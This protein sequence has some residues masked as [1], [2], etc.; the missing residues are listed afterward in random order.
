MG[1]W[2]V[3]REWLRLIALST[4]L[5]IPVPVMAKDTNEY[6]AKF[7]FKNKTAGQRDAL[8]FEILGVLPRDVSVKF[9]K[10]SKMQGPITLDNLTTRTRVRASG[11]VRAVNPG[12]T[13][14][15]EIRLKKKEEARI[16]D[17]RWGLLVNG[18]VPVPLPPLGKP[19][20]TGGQWKLDPEFT[21]FNDTEDVPFGI[22]NLQLFTN[23]STDDFEMLDPQTFF[24]ANPN[25]SLPSFLLSPGTNS[26]DQGLKFEMFPEPDVGMWLVATGQL[27]DDTGET[28]GA[29]IHGV[30]AVPEPSTLALCGGGLI[31]LRALASRRRR[32]RAE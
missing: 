3:L 25:S 26:A 11:I 2:K 23:V 24:G 17:P 13:A 7:T 30:Q 14:D 27:Y 31:G 21:L 18:T 8:S 20:I 16:G 29:F 22:R 9:L 1:T 6:V 5:C 12:E 28:V 4:L 19:E 10:G 32:R 15:I